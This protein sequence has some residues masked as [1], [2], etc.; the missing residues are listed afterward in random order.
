MEDVEVSF[1]EVHKIVVDYTQKVCSEVDRIL[2]SALRNNAEPPIKGEITYNKIKWRGI[3]KIE[4]RFFDRTET[5]LEQ[6]GKR[7]SEK[8]IINFSINELK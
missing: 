6:R 2:E 4:Q 3:R 8:I 1:L 7:I 5:W